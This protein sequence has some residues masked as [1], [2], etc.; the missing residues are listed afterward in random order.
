MSV[1]C[2][3]PA[4]GRNFSWKCVKAMGLFLYRFGK[5]GG[6]SRVQKEDEQRPVNEDTTK[7]PPMSSRLGWEFTIYA[8][9]GLPGPLGFGASVGGYYEADKHLEWSTGMGSVG[10][11]FS[12]LRNFFK[13][14]RKQSKEEPA[15]LPKE[16]S[17]DV[18]AVEEL[19]EP[20][21]SPGDMDQISEE[22]TS[23]DTSE[24]DTTLADEVVAA[25]GASSDT[26]TTG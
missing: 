26:T 13:N 25:T 12:R 2:A 10:S 9:A 11:A 21:I 18:K 22:D 8:H 6:G 1:T 14:R 5:E 4:L 17:D 16:L 24:E 15:E 20:I 23:P 3:R 7:E 19:R